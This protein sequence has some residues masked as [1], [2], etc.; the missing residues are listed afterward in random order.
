MKMDL[1]AQA[2]YLLDMA[3]KFS[4]PAEMGADRIAGLQQ[5]LDAYLAEHQ[6]A[7]SPMRPKH[8]LG[9][10]PSELPPHQGRHNTMIPKNTAN[11]PDVPPSPA[12]PPQG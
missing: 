3:V 7:S 11:L 2:A 12:R 8:G 9:K 5:E 1:I 10:S 6:G 4:D